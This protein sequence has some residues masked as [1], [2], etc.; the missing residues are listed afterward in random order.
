MFLPWAKIIDIGVFGRVGPEAF[1]MHTA[2]SEG[3]VFV[4]VWSKEFGDKIF[5]DFIIAINKADKVS[6]CFFETL[7][8][9]D[10][11]TLVFLMNDFDA[12]ILFGILVGN[13]AGIISGAVVY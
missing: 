3:G 11:L 10:G 9:G 5:G 7:I 12:G 4:F 1:V 8:S 6:G 2:D 13:L